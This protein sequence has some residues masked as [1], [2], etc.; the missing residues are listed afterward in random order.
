MLI[1]E[2]PLHHVILLSVHLHGDANCHCILSGVEEDFTFRE[3]N[4]T[5]LTF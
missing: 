2:L 1:H 4:V 5:P 3:V